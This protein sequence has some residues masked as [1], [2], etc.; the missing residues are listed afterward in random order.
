MFQFHQLWVADGNVASRGELIMV[1]ENNLMSL[2]AGAEAFVVNNFPCTFLSDNRVLI[3][4]KLFRETDYGQRLT[5][6]SAANTV[7]L[8]FIWLAPKALEIKQ[9]PSN[10]NWLQWQTNIR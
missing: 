1:A 3:D 7:M 5:E 10:A 2:P 8:V 4:G 9:L 6:N